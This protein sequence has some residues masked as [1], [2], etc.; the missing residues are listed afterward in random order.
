DKQAV[1][2][3]KAGIKE[4]LIKAGMVRGQPRLSHT[5]TARATAQSGASGPSSG[6][7][8]AP[9]GQQ[10]YT[11]PLSMSAPAAY[12]GMGYEFA[13]PQDWSVQSQAP[14]A[15]QHQHQYQPMHRAT[16]YGPY[17]SPHALGS[18]SPHL[19]AQQQHV[20]HSPHAPAVMGAE[21]DYLGFPMAS[22][23]G[24]GQ[25]QQQERRA[26][27][28]VPPTYQHQYQARM[29]ETR[30][31]RAQVQ[32]QQQQFQ[33]PL[34]GDQ[35]SYTASPYSPLGRSV[36]SSSQDPLLD[37]NA[38]P[39][40]FGASMSSMSPAMGMHSVGL[41]N[42][43]TGVRGVTSSPLMLPGDESLLFSNAYATPSQQ[44][45]QLH[46]QPPDPPPIRLDFDVCFQRV[47]VMP[48]QYV[49]AA[50]KARGVLQNLFAH[51]PYGP[52]VNASCA[53]AARHNKAIRVARL[54]DPPDSDPLQSTAR[55]FFDRAYW[56]LST[57]IPHTA[58]DALASLHLVA[59]FL[60]QGGSGDWPTCLHAAR[61]W[62]AQTH[63]CAPDNETPR[64]T[65]AVM[66]EAEQL[67][68][69]MTIWYDIIAAIS[70]RQTPRFL[71]MYR[72]LLGGTIS[73]EA[74]VQT[75]Q[76]ANMTLPMGCPD[77]V[78][79]ILAETAALAQWKARQRQLGTLSNRELIVRGDAIEHRL[80]VSTIAETAERRP[81]VYFPGTRAGTGADVATAT[82][83]ATVDAQMR[84]EYSTSSPPTAAASAAVSSSD[85]SALMTPVASGLAVPAPAP[86]PAP[87]PFSASAASLSVFTT[88][89]DDN[90]LEE[91]RPT[92]LN[93]RVGQVFLHTAALYLA[94]VINEPNP[95]ITEINSAANGLV[96]A[97]NDL[98]DMTLDRALVLP[99]TLAGSM[100]G[101]PEQYQFVLARLAAR[102]EAIGNIRSVRLL[103]ER[104][105][106]TRNAHGGGAIAIDWRDV[107]RNDMNME[108]LL[109]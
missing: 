15:H 99:L 50:E 21:F 75:V 86:A 68:V 20:P 37:F 74:S 16:R 11:P 100:T 96:N 109:V 97:L 108:L 22:G 3:Y 87:G 13:P 39:F 44:Q 1:E 107:M 51:D 102:D 82:A 52:L 70:L 76:G 45:Q 19:A 29:L 90:A 106:A 64:K 4:K 93:K 77:D 7:A 10:H 53:L 34:E 72:R 18:Y 73:R 84:P 83:T 63:L 27:L 9:Q 62:L 17:P 8:P 101:L 25:Q 104:V 59:Y 61:E 60:M 48:L 67:A 30:R 92:D 85:N 2:V 35:E 41:A 71:A 94:S 42:T 56:Q 78:L 55:Q 54:L 36:S 32:Q 65:L 103:I 5:H 6:A 43:I 46:S 58:A 26:S 88:K 14:L 69:K 79:L 49:F 47:G 95:S 66:D 33:L 98:P 105:W 38:S 89:N 28:A 31:R 24:S 23:S 80:L 91:T 40:D 81:A 12:G 57:R